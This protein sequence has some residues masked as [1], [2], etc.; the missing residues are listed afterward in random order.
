M[1]SSDTC[2][3]RPEESLPSWVISESLRLLRL[4][5]FAI[6]MRTIRQ[7]RARDAARLYPLDYCKAVQRETFA[8]YEGH[9]TTKV[10]RRV[11]RGNPADCSSAA[12]VSCISVRPRGRCS[13]IPICPCKNGSW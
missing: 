7:L 2:C 3:P 4:V 12:S 1:P 9:M 5:R 6:H 13:M 11:I 10:L 8:H